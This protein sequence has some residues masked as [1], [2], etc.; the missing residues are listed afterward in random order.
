MSGSQ[1]ASTRIA[2]SP[3]DASVTAKPWSCSATEVSSRLT[4][5]SSTRSTL[6]RSGRSSAKGSARRVMKACPGLTAWALRLVAR[7][8]ARGP[9]RRSRSGSPA[10]VSARIEVSI[11]AQ[12]LA[13][14]RAPMLADDD[15]R[16]W[17]TWRMPCMSS[18]RA[19]R[20]TE[21]PGV[22]PR[23]RRRAAR[24]RAGGS[25]R[26]DRARAGAP[27]ASASRTVGVSCAH[28]GKARG[29]SAP[30][31]AARGRARRRK[32]HASE[33]SDMMM[34]RVHSE[35][36]APPARGRR[37]PRPHGAI[38]GAS[39]ADLNRAF[40]HA[41]TQRHRARRC[42]R[43]ATASGS[44]NSARCLGT[45][46]PPCGR[47]RFGLEDRAPCGPDAAPSDAAGAGP[48]R[49]LPAS[50]SPRR[51][52]PSWRCS[53]LAAL[54]LPPRR[55]T[56]ASI[57][58]AAAAGTQRAIRPAPPTKPTTRPSATSSR[59]TCARRSASS[60][61]SPRSSRKTTARSLDR[62]GHDHLDRVLGAAARM[63]SMID[64]L[65]QLSQ[66]V[67]AADRARAGEPV[68]DRRLRGRRPAAPAA[69]ARGRGRD[70]AAS[71]SPRAIR[72]CCACC[73]RTCS[74]T[75]GSTPRNAEPCADR[76]G[77]PR[78]RDDRLHGA[79]Q[80]RRLRHALCR[81]PVRRLPAPAQRERVPRHR[82]RPRLGAPHRAPPSRRGL[83]RVGARAR[84]PL[85]LHAAAR[86]AR[87][88]AA[89]GAESPRLQAGRLMP[90]RPG[91]LLDRGEQ[92]LGLR[93]Q[94]EPLGACASRCSRSPPR[95]GPA[96]SDA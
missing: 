53:S 21:R 70:R 71:C 36:A 58:A 49:R 45:P 69:R 75:P 15:F 13:S 42:A 77:A 4:S 11:S 28:D 30:R 12:I 10:K 88:E 16:V 25:G 43:V 76:P 74:A 34:A 65:L 20:R 23:S 18:A 50:P 72:R 73:S 55:T 81:P 41:R 79:R 46:F 60:K 32:R 31:R 3:L 35:A 37:Q 66:P 89:S 56:P 27:S 63:N 29:S 59:T 26:S 85:P 68:A 9:W 38:F 14:A 2:F 90:R 51:S 52:A 96:S 47:V 91:E 94:R 95:R 78:R 22:S 1:S 33:A 7:P 39:A 87:R 19:R 92:Q 82:R 93:V 61:A 48:C 83:G 54:P 62:V 8:S 44:Y 6:G 80:R 5:S 84:R 64:A 86:A 17:T 24:A 57:D 67:L 40:P